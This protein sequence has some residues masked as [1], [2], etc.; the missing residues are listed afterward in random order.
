VD[1]KVVTDADFAAI[2][3]WNDHW[4]WFSGQQLTDG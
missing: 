2:Q 1:L 4:C 3:A